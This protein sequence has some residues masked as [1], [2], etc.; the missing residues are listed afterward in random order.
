MRSSLTLLRRAFSLVE[1]LVVIAIIA[2]LISILLPRL[3]AARQQA[4]SVQCLS[5]L[6]TCGQFFMIY[7]NQNKG[8]LS[9]ADYDSCAKFPLEGANS[10]VLNPA[11]GVTFKYPGM[12]EALDRIANPNS[13]GGRIPNP[14]GTKVNPLWHIGNLIVFYCPAQYIWDT[15][16]HGSGSSHWPDDF[17]ATGLIQYFYL[18]CPNPLYP[19]CHYA[20]GFNADGGP[21]NVA[22]PPASL[23][24]FFYD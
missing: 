13:P 22:A 7:A 19:S 17:M 8:F 15:D 18:G 23:D 12:R 10:G 6:R 3:Q 11:T 14:P 9:E 5:N 2:V 21:T 20:G 24:R 16:A 1:L 4:L